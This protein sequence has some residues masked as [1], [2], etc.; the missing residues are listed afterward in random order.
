[1]T[2][3]VKKMAFGGMG[4]RMFA[5]RRPVAPTQSNIVG[6][7]Q[8]MGV[9]IGNATKNIGPTP[10]PPKPGSPEMAEAIKNTEMMKS[11]GFSNPGG[12]PTGPNA[13]D[14]VKQNA[15]AVNNMVG[16]AAGAGKPMK[17]GGKVRTASQRADGCAIRGKTRA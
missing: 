11:M 15:G 2:K 9:G 17:K 14:V 6:K 1:M 10:P 7:P 8:P 13:F 16:A 5:P 3:K 4:G 12:T